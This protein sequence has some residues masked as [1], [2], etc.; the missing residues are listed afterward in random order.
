MNPDLTTTYTV[1]YTGTDQPTTI[2][3]KIRT[4][5]RSGIQITSISGLAPLLADQIDAIKDEGDRLHTL[6]VLSG[7]IIAIADQDRPGIAITATTRDHGRLA[8]TY[9]GTRD[10]P[11]STVLDLAE[12][13]RDTLCP[14]APSS[15]QP[16][17]P[18][19]P[20]EADARHTPQRAP[21]MD[22]TT[23]IRATGIYTIQTTG[24]QQ[25]PSEH[26]TSVWQAPGVRLDLMDGRHLLA[27][28]KLECPPRDADE[29]AARTTAG[30][31]PWVPVLRHHLPPITTLREDLARVSPLM[32]EVRAYAQIGYPEAPGV[33]DQILPYAT[34]EEIASATLRGDAE[35][36]GVP[37][38]EQVITRLRRSI[39][40]GLRILLAHAPDPVAHPLHP[41]WQQPG[42]GCEV[43]AQAVARELLAAWADIRASR[44]S[45]FTWAI[46]DAGLTRSEV[47][48]TTGVARTTIDRMLA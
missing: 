13:L 23:S 29:L 40:A 38:A 21:A 11:V 27:V 48:R 35:P 19:T 3:P 1:T 25:W 9:Q 36:L 12:R 34:D 44:D 22:I 46:G 39:Q 15:T 20:S 7:S 43:T 42:R 2:T 41:A 6:T 8:T 45:L 24:P 26:D 14:P 28:C 16:S 30:I 32:D 17:D 5:D 31:E 33:I 18:T 10:L 47:Q 37:L 4:R